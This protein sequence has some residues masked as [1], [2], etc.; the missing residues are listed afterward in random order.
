MTSPY[1]PGES[2]TAA[3]LYARVESRIAALELATATVAKVITRSSGSSTFA[4][5]TDTT[6]GGWDTTAYD[7]GGIG[8]GSGVFTAPLPGLYWWS[9]TLSTPATTPAY[10]VTLRVQVNGLLNQSGQLQTSVPANSISQA[11][12]TSGPL[13]L[14]ANDTVTL[15]FQ[16]TSG[17]SMAVTQISAAL[18]RLA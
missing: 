18:V 4:N 7:K 2:I 8:Y 15:R 11:L 17:A 3:K 1:V 13:V 10:G 16:Q 14:N 9:M 5:N 6:V 12:P